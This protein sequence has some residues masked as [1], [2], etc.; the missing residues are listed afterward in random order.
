M[1]DF[2]RDYK[3][4]KKEINIGIKR[5]LESG[6][7]LLGQELKLFELEL[8]NYLNVKYCVG[9][10]NGTEAITLALIA[11][12][13]KPGDEV[14]TTNMSAYPTITGIERTGAKAV[15]VDI[16][17]NT[18]LM[19]ISKI[20]VKINKNTKAIV[21][22]HLYGQACNMDEIIKIAKNH[23]LKIMEDCAQSIGAK[24][25]NKTT[26]TFGNAGSLSFYPT[27]NLG[28]YGDAGAVITNDEDVYKKLLKLRNYGQSIRYYHEEWGINSRLD[29]IQAAI[30]RAKL[31]KLDENIEKRRKIAHFYNTHLKTVKY[32]IENKDCLSTYHLYVIKSKHRD[33]LQAYLSEYNIS[34]LIHYPVPLNMQKA[35][36]FQKEDKFPNTFKFANEILSIPIYPELALNEV[37]LVVKVIN[38]FKPKN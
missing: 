11:I 35:F 17:E 33:E 32:I 20:E 8:S 14:I 21:P 19:D 18:G 9:L 27:K 30:L 29:E 7:Y 31:K 37:R 13:I 38:Q 24:Y 10:A 15:L 3:K 22:V 4:N 36:K 12:G 25:K 28:A 16:D 6:W 34:T 23:N 1:N 2:S 5:V 26:G